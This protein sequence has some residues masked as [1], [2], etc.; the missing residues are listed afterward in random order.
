MPIIS[1][2]IGEGRSMERKR[3]FI[4]ALTQATVETMDV[5]PDQV[6]VILNETPLDHY[7]VAGVTFGEKAQQGQSR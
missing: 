2:V 3:A 1:V 6:R 5:R 7:A 4:R